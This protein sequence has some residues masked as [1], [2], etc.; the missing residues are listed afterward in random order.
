MFQT[1]MKIITV[2]GQQY[3]VL[4]VIGKGGSSKVGLLL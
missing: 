2:N 1:N 3:G 4:G